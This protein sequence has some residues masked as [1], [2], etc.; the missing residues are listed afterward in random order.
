M[1][2]QGECGEEGGAAGVGTEG[3]RDGGKEGGGTLQEWR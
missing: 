2:A 3:K 1:G